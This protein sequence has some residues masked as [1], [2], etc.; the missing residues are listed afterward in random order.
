MRFGVV[1]RGFAVVILLAACAATRLSADDAKKGSMGGYS[2][3]AF[4][5][6]GYLSTLPET[7]EVSSY[8]PH[9]H[10]LYQKIV[11]T[12]FLS[13]N[14]V[15]GFNVDINPAMS[16]EIKPVMGSFNWKAE[17]NAI[18]ALLSRISLTLHVRY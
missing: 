9:G 16:F 11:F 10:H 12:P 15:A 17:P 14:A 1:V 7:L 2:V 8:A 6:P 3:P 5:R 18:D 4:E 13:Y